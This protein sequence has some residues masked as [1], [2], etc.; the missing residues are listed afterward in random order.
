MSYIW[1]NDGG[2][3]TPVLNAQRLSFTPFSGGS[4]G[5]TY[6]GDKFVLAALIPTLEANGYAVDYQFD[7]SPIAKLSFSAAYSYGNASNGGAPV[8]PNTDYADT[9]EL[10]RNTVQKELL[11]SDHPYV[12]ELSSAD[13]VLLKTAFT[14]SPLALPTFTGGGTSGIIPGGGSWSSATSIAAATYLYNLF[15]S[16]VKTVEVKQPILRVTRTTSPA[17]NASFNV[18]NIDTLLYTSSMISDANVPGGFAIPLISLSNRLIARSGGTTAQARTDGLNLQF[19]W[20][21]NLVSSSKHGNQRIQ[22]ITEYIF[23]LYDTA[24]YGVPS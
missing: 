19:G 15:A 17:Y 1:N 21:K 5:G 2:A 16:G 6:T 3:R 22:Y 20:L 13:F 23:G 8:S 11:E 7:Q 9:W 18:A 24:L 12:S 10:V 14:T 4:V